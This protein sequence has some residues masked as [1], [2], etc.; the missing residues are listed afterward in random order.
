MCYLSRR[1]ASFSARGVRILGRDVGSSQAL[2][3]EGVEAGKVGERLIDTVILD[4]FIFPA[5]RMMKLLVLFAL[6][7]LSLVRL[8]SK[9]IRAHAKVAAVGT[10][11]CSTTY[12]LNPSI[13]IKGAC[14]DAAI[15]RSYQ[16]LHPT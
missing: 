8:V 2:S 11:V 15:A 14:I 10:K 3:G 1:L 16:R 7:Q 9:V 4:S 6:L 13:D 12:Y 5:L